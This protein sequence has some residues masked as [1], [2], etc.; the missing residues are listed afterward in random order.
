[1]AK[2][3]HV[4]CTYTGGGIYVMTAKLNDDTWFTTDLDLY[5][6]YDVPWEDIEEKYDCDYDAHWKDVPSDQL[7]TW[8]EVLNAITNSYRKGLSRNM[9]LSEVRAILRENHPRLA[10]KVDGTI[11]LPSNKTK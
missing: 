10:C 1:M 6:T 5:G 8:K 11:D 3:T 9:D 2:L 7:P 4:H